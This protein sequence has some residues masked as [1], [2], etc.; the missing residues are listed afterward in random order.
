MM[1]DTLNRARSLRI[2][3]RIASWVVIG[4]LGAPALRVAPAAAV[5]PQ[6]SLPHVLESEKVYRA[7][8]WAENRGARLTVLNASVA[9]AYATL[10]AA[11]GRQLLVL[12]TEWENIIPWTVIDQQ[13]IPTTY[14][15]PQLADHVYVVTDGRRRRDCRAG[16]RR[17][18]Q[19]GN[20]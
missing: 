7:L 9:P 12:A 16:C 17:S 18:S 10:K 4:L 13:N 3:I 14:K 1:S 19:A 2:R 15:I 20:P 11:P 8:T 5:T 6:P